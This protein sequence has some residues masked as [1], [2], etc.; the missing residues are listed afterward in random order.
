MTSMRS[1]FSACVLAAAATLTF[2]AQPALAGDD[3]NETMQAV[4]LR[5][6]AEDGTI[7]VREIGSNQKHTIRFADGEKVPASR[8]YTFTGLPRELPLER[9]EIGMRLSIRQSQSDLV[10]RAE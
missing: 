7:V 10:A 3:D 2:G 1:I 4:V 8:I 6:D 5:V 9:V